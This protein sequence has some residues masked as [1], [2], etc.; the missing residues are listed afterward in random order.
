MK[1]QTVK[2]AF[3]GK[4]GIGKS[5]IAAN[6]SAALGA[7]GKRVLHIGCDPKADSAR[8]LTEKK[9]PTVL[10]QIN[11]LGENLSRKDIV[12]PGA[13]GVSCVEAGG[14]RA[15]SGCAGMGI[16]AMEEE[17]NRLHILEEGWDAVIYDVLGDVVCGGF[18][19]P[20]RRHYVQ[21]VFVVTSADFM[22]LYAANNIMKGI[23]SCCGEDGRMLGGLILNHCR[24][25]TDREIA[26]AFSERT[27][28]KVLFD[29]EESREI[30]LSDYQKTVV[31][32][33]YPEGKAAK[34]FQMLAKL[35]A[36]QGEGTLPRPLDGEEMEGFG[37]TIF[38]KRE[39]QP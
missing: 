12:F 35:A 18:S 29:L 26:A 32:K 39:W 3:Y 34:A 21:K 20:M 30:R 23:R 25:E 11:L 24:S 10:E 7:A 8:C 31:Q 6:V 1:E 28:A 16:T 4:G 22:S 38:E 37:R 9:I 13:Y 36:G 14:P 15:G 17:L 27:G 5:T 2:I 33:A 19:V